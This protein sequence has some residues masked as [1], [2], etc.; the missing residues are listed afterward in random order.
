MIDFGLCK[1]YLKKD[2]L[3][4]IGIKENKKMIGTPIFSSLNMHKG[5]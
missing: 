2:S 5:L 4:H 1:K 3:Q